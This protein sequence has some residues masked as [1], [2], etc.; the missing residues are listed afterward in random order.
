MDSALFTTLQQPVRSI[1]TNA[2]QGVF[3]E[4]GGILRNG[5]NVEFGLENA[6]WCYLTELTFALW[7]RCVQGKK[8]EAK[9]FHRFLLD[10]VKP[11]LKVLRTMKQLE[12]QIHAGLLQLGHEVQEAKLRT[13]ASVH[14]FYRK[15]IAR[16]LQLEGTCFMLWRRTAVYSTQHKCRGLLRLRPSMLRN[17]G[18]ELIVT[19]VILSGY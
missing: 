19:L 5:M 2:M 3:A 11:I 7:T 15:Y 9:S 4:L 6:R 18:M 1:Q 13:A 17:P 14:A 16:R 10:Y 12:E 8:V